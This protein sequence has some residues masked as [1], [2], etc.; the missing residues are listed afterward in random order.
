M[1]SFAVKLRGM[2]KE[3]TSIHL[4]F[5][6]SIVFLLLSQALIFTYFT[7][8]TVAG[9]SIT[10][11]SVT[12]IAATSISTDSVCTGLTASAGSL[13]ALVD[14]CRKQQQL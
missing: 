4:N 10:A 7:S 11:E 6:S 5:N 2:K 1:Q 3:E 14:V 9:T 8:L 12:S 13:G